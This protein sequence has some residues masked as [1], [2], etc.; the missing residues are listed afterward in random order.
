MSAIYRNLIITFLISVG[1]GC[2]ATILIASSENGYVAGFILLPLFLFIGVASLILFIVGLICLGVKSKSAPW[3]LLSAILLPAS[4]ISSAMIAKYFEIGAYHQEP[5]IPMSDEVNN[6]VVFKE[7]T[8]NDQINDFWEKTMSLE[9]ADGRGYDHLPGVR[10]MG[11]DKPRNGRETMIFDFFPSATEEQQQFVFS[12]VKS[13]PIVYQLLE[14]ES[15][16]EQS[17]S[18]LLT[19]KTGESKKIETVN[20]IDSK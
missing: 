6:V 3:L 18:S 13:S 11:Q 20:S 9:R 5:M 14:N 16:K 10:V 15:L 2:G 17:D 1:G 4:F 19:M 8:T 12:R 7:G